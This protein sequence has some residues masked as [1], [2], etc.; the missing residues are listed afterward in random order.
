MPKGKQGSN[1]ERDAE[2]KKAYKADRKLR[3]AHLIDAEEQKQVEQMRK[4]VVTAV[5]AGD[6]QTALDKLKERGYGPDSREYR[7]VIALLYPP[8]RRK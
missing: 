3:P 7:A 1:G 5:Q 8:G 6:A 4:E 2:I